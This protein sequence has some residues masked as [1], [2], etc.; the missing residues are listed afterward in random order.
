M[1][2]RITPPEF[3]RCVSHQPGK[4]PGKIIRIVEAQIQGDTGHGIL[5]VKKPVLGMFYPHLV[6]IGIHIHTDP[7]LE[8][9]VDIGFAAVTVGRHI[10]YRNRGRVIS[11]DILQRVGYNGILVGINAPGWKFLPRMNVPKVKIGTGQIF[12]G[13]L[14]KGKHLFD[15]HP[16]GNNIPVK[17]IACR[18]VIDLPRGPASSPYKVPG[19][20]RTAGKVTRGDSPKDKF[21]GFDGYDIFPY[22]RVADPVKGLTLA[23][24]YGHGPH[25]AETSKVLFLI[26]LD[27]H[28]EGI[29]M[30]AV[31]LEDMIQLLVYGDKTRKVLK[32][33][34][35]I[36]GPADVIQ[37]LPHLFETSAHN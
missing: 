7:F 1:F 16:G 2:L 35:D 25:H 34:A 14:K 33:D 27:I 11:A 37:K 15:V 8:T 17:K 12:G 23:A 36:V 28:T 13:N 5:A 22:P 26:R 32:T 21:I 20:F 31:G 18:I 24:A 4:N 10:P 6:D 3:R 9:V 19:K 29:G 30:G